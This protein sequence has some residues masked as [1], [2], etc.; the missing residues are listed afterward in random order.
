MSSEIRTVPEM[1]LNGW[2]FLPTSTGTLFGDTIAPD[3][4]FL[5][6][7][8]LVGGATIIVVPFVMA[9]WWYA[10]ADH[11]LK[12]PKLEAEMP[13]RRR[14]SIPEDW[15]LPALAIL[16]AIAVISN[17][18]LLAAVFGW[19]GP[20]Q[21]SIRTGIV[22]PAKPF[23]ETYAF[24]AYD[25][26]QVRDQFF[27]IQNSLPPLLVL[28]TAYEFEARTVA[29]GLF[30]GITLA[31]VNVTPPIV[32]KALNPQETGI[33]IRVA[34]FQQNSNRREGSRR[35]ASKSLGSGAKIY[36]NARV[37]ERSIHAFHWVKSQ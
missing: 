26:R 22:K 17:W 4:G 8:I 2:K 7:E 35:C 14:W 21:A 15:R 27:N 32:T 13:P 5:M 34:I 37:T 30:G 25:A 24:T 3:G 11:L 16:G 19:I 29:D 20:S 36:G 9:T 23:S 18:I 12:H 31:G 6:F 28:Q 1:G 33:F 10:R